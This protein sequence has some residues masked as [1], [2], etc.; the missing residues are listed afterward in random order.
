MPGENQVA[1]VVFHKN[2]NPHKWVM[3]HADYLYAFAY[4]R[5]NNEEQ[6]KD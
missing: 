3:L 2:I 5:I 6:A 1:D 4:T